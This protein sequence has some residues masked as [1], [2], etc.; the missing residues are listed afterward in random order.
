M[1]ERVAVIGLGYVGLPVAL[2]F[3]RKFPGSI[4]FDI[5]VEKVKELRSG[6]DRTG[7]IAAEVLKGSSLEMTWDLDALKPA[8]FYVV[9]VPTPVDLNNR[10]DLT[11]VIKAS[12]TVGKVLKKGDVVVYESTVYPGVTE[13]LCG[14]ILAKLSGLQQGVDF[15][16]GYSPE[17]I[18]PGDKLH[19][20]ERIT[21]VVSGEDAGTL[22]RVA[23]TYGAI[24]E[25][26]VFKATSIKV[27]EAAK[28]IENTQRDLNIALMNE[29]ALIFD[30][31]GIRTRDV[32]AAAGTK[33]NFLKFT[34]GL[35]G[36]HCIGVD[37]YYLTTKAEELGY[38]PQ[39][40]LA[41]RR[42]NNDIAPYVAQRTV[43]LLVHQGLPVKGARVGVFGLTFKE[44]VA[45]IRNS[46]V[47]DILKELKE[48]G[49]DAKLTDPYA[50]PAETK[51]EYG[52]GLTKLEEM[53]DL[54][55]LILAVSHSQYVGQPLSFLLE[56]IKPGGVLVD[57]K[58]A[59]N[60]AEIPAGRVSYWC[61]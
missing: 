54:D 34:P 10:P 39:V 48:F 5:N 11:P 30:R 44:N 4:G 14:P 25:A 38:Q 18:N 32:L 53:R 21:K 13:D 40:I 31:M 43:K 16:L 22:E 29:L 27:A 61:L 9:A 37:P 50:D 20:L 19:T 56:R 45:D 52:L 17:R 57:V 8:T 41:G 28:V 42:I 35:V 59:I 6:F 49:I 51:H 26:G 47:P 3:A 12:E 46:K 60:P 55:A 24:I 2:A 1:S 7:E 33:W 36:G 58:S 15:K 23:A